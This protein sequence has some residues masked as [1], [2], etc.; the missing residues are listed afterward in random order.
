MLAIT[1][2]GE[3][4]KELFLFIGDS[5]FTEWQMS[6]IDEFLSLCGNK[7]R[8]GSSEE[9]DI[10]GRGDGKLSVTVGG[11]GKGEVC[12]REEYSTLYA[13]ASI[14][15]TWF[16]AHLCAG[17]PLTDIYDFNA[18]ESGKLIVEEEFFQGGWIHCG[19]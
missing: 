17:I 2:G 11:G 1:A 10:C 6:V 4:G 15:V 14:Q 3:D 9:G 8:L 16:D 12:E 5:Y 19:N 13:A 7:S 18:V